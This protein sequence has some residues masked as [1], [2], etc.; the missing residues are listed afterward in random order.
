MTTQAD[1]LGLSEI[2]GYTPAAL[3]AI[4][5]SAGVQLTLI[6]QAFGGASY[7][8]NGQGL[9]FWSTALLLIGG[10]G[11]HVPWSQLSSSLDTDALAEAKPARH[12]QVLLAPAGQAPA[13]SQAPSPAPAPANGHASKQAAEPLVQTQGSSAEPATATQPAP[14]GPAPKLKARIHSPLAK[15]PVVRPGEPVPF[16]IEAQPKELAEEL[17]VTVSVKTDEGTR[18]STAAMKDTT[19]V[20]TETFDQAGVFEIV[21]TL[22]HPGAPPA[23]QTIQGRVASYREE[24]GRIFEELKARCQKAGLAVGPHSTPREVCSELRTARS[25]KAEQLAELAI[26]LEVALYGDKEIER[27]TYEAVYQAVQAIQLPSPGVTG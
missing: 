6:I 5:F 3:L 10:L 21:I 8:P 11:L 14:S 7:P 19:L 13:T 22:E 18:K 12:R 24:V 23:S 27:H 25:A 1:R 26:E 15:G 16:T 9:L 4:A 17:E 20:H 2:P